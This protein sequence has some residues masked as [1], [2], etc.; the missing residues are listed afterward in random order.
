MT[1]S[2]TDRYGLDAAPGALGLVQD[3]LNTVAGGPREADLLADLAAAQEWADSAA[4]QWS[5]V[6]GH[7]ISPIVLDAGG[8][9]ELRA[10]RNDLQRVTAHRVSMEGEAEA[11]K[12]VPILHG[13]AAALQ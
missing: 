2:A 5:A 9:D 12:A 7:P 11:V 4:H 10:F 8:L 3:L 1:W 13:A 6:T